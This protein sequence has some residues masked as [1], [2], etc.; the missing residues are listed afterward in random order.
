MRDPFHFKYPALGPNV[1]VCHC[2][3]RTACI[4]FSLS[5]FFPF[6]LILSLGAQR[7]SGWMS[8]RING[9]PLPWKLEQ[10]NNY[11]RSSIQN[12]DLPPDHWTRLGGGHPTVNT[13]L[14]RTSPASPSCSAR[15][16]SHLQVKIHLRRKSK[17]NPDFFL[18]ITRLH[19]SWAHSFSQRW[20]AGFKADILRK[21]EKESEGPIDTSIFQGTKDK[22]RLRVKDSR[23]KTQMDPW[24]VF[25]NHY[26]C[27]WET[28]V[29]DSQSNASW[30][31]W[32]WCWVRR[33]AGTEINRRS[34]MNVFI[35][36]L[37]LEMFN[38]VFLMAHLVKW[39]NCPK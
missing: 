34:I 24:S 36:Y 17:C 33:N 22:R 2:Q 28:P 12:R 25:F 9:L 18:P 23:A 39:I 3:S 4:P 10:S 21:T 16:H 20:A 26:W 14:P 19:Y 7:D 35:F 1:P 29:R 38:D 32:S 31:N 13:Y 8:L 6:I 27:F 30:F 37:A 15:F 11:S 5:R